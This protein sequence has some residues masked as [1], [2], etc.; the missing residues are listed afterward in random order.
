MF[1]SIAGVGP[2]IANDFKSIEG[3]REFG[4]NTIPVMFGARGASYI[5]A[6][7]QTLTQIGIALYLFSINEPTYATI[8][9]GLIVPQVYF[10]ATLLIP[11]PIANQVQFQASTQPLFSLGL[12]LTALCEGRHDWGAHSMV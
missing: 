8:L 9:L 11:D 7:T 10:Q 4:M 6:V 12:L 2:A 1:Y 5:C 3:D